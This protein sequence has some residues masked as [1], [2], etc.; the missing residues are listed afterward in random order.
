[1]GRQEWYSWKAKWNC[2]NSICDRSF[3]KKKKIL[4]IPGIGKVL[5]VM[6]YLFGTL[7]LSVFE[8]PLS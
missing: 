2:E 1:M 3:K 6:I 8:W 5:P 7:V 4:C